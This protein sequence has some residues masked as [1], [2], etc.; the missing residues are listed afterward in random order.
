MLPLPKKEIDAIPADRA[1][2]DI[3][4]KSINLIFVTPARIQIISSGKNGK[5]RVKNKISLVRFDKNFSY[6]STFSFVKIQ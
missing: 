5:N 2:S 3:H 1:K 6:L 4:K